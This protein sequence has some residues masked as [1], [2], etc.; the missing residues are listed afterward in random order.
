MMS[1]AY[2]LTSPLGTSGTLGL[3]V[4]QT[5]ETIEHDFRRLLGTHNIALY[6]NRIPSGADLTPETI[7]DMEEQLPTAASLLPTSVEFDA[8]GYGCTS[9]ST[10]IGPV[11]VARLVKRTCN[12]PFVAD[13]LTATFDAMRTLNVQSIGLVSPYIETVAATMKSEFERAGFQVPVAL[14]FGEKTEAKVARIDPASLREAA[15]K[16][17]QEGEMD[18]IFL[19]CTNLRTLD[20]IHDLESELGVPIL[21]SNLTLAWRMLDRAGA[22]DIVK[23]PGRLFQTRCQVR[24]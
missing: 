12:T 5:D 9:A 20:I 13:P 7:A 14:S 22:L 3:I 18:A 19:S 21:S 16:V 6:V 10:L 23:G 4:L 11:Q 17:W 1:H 8:V 2:N 15:L 24:Q